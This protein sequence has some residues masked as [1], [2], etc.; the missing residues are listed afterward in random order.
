M[1]SHLAEE[2]PLRWSQTD[3]ICAQCVEPLAYTEEIILLQIAQ[4]EVHEGVVRLT[5]VLDEEG[6]F[7]YG[8]YFL[9][10]M[11]W[12]GILE[13]HAE[14]VVNIPPTTDSMS[15]L[16]CDCCKSGIR[17]WEYC[18]ALTMGE[19]HRS[20]RSPSGTGHGP[21]LVESGAPDILC[22]PCISAI[23]EEWIEFWETGI[24]QEHECTL[25]LNARCWRTFDC[26]CTCHAPAPEETT[27]DD[28]S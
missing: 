24:A 8:P 3:E 10:Y 18:A 23:N 5:P 19:F 26:D 4:P 6:D 28:Q 21:E 20:K 22:L 13:G 12:E 14:E 17:E 25:C 27:N 7:L 15:I 1:G 16:E 11:C 2:N 9:H